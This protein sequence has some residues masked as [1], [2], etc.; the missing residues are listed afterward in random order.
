MHCTG[1]QRIVSCSGS[2]ERE[3]MSVRS[4]IKEFE[5]LAK[6]NEGSDGK[7]SEASK[8]K[9]T[10]CISVVYRTRHMVH[11]NKYCLHFV[12]MFTEG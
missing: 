4:R 6:A 2:T 5:E 7:R 1:R 8:S 12:Y 3:E 10:S 9:L 11:A